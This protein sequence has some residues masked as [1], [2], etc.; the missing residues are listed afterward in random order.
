MNRIVIGTR[1]SLL[2]RWQTDWVKTRIAQLHPGLEVEVQV[3]TTTGDRVLDTSLPKLG[4]QGKGLFT[5]EIEEALLDGRADVAVHSLKDLPTEITPGLHIGAILER[6][7]VRDAFVARPGIESFTLL[8]RGGR[9]GTSSLRRTAQLRAVRTDLVIEPVR[10]NVDTRLRK[11]DSGQYDALV[12]AAA[13][14]RRLGHADRITEYF[15]EEVMLPAV[16]QGAVAVQTR[17]ADPLVNALVQPLNHLP[18]EQ[19]C[20]AERAYLK[21]LGGGCLVP[22]AALARVEEGQLTI[23]GLVACPDGSEILRGRDRGLAEDGYSIGLRLAEVLL[24]KG[25]DRLLRSP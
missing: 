3:I 14:L 15:S 23:E 7:D 10:G 17:S 1:G 2:A 18:T 21:G 9:V 16:G 12:L 24:S 13:G 4:E 19:A 22:I 25:A 11:L 8:P 20:R 6:E 5:K